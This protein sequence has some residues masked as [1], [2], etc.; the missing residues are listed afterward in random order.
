[1]ETGLSTL[2]KGLDDRPPLPLISRSGSATD[3]LP[4]SDVNDAVFMTP[5][6]FTV[7]IAY[8]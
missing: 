2:S 4:S 1:M 8:R 7:L 5:G 3:S 6:S